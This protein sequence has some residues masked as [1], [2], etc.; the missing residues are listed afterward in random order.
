[1]TGGIVVVLGEAGRNFGAGMTGGMAYVL[2]EEEIFARR[3]N[4][5]LVM[6]RRIADA[7]SAAH[8][9]SLIAAH[10]AATDSAPARNLLADW[11]R[12]MPRFW[13]VL[14]RAPAVTSV[15]P[16]NAECRQPR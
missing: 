2:D 7:A 15:V 16:A 3:Y 4:P 12:W 1:M 11:E 14:P 6:I 5:S 10:V 13:H 9:K 8:L